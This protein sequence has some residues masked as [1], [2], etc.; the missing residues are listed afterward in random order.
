MNEEG[1]MD[2]GST[3]AC[4]VAGSQSMETNAQRAAH[5]DL[6]VRVRLK[7]LDE[8]VNLFGELLV[9]RSILEE[10]VSRLVQLVSD[11]NV[12]SNHLRDVGQKLESRFEATT[13]PSSHSIQM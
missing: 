9:N 2:D 13:L 5:G 12:S 1:L 10:R 4:V 11:I 7:K 6:S 8:L 3:V